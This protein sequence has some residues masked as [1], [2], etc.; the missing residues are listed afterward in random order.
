MRILKKGTVVALI[1]LFLIACLPVAALAAEDTH[2]VTYVIDGEV[3][4]TQEVADGADAVAPEIP[5][6][7]GYTQIAP[8]WDHDGKNIT[9]DISI[10][11]R[12][13]INEY[14][15]T[16]KVGD[17]TYKKL[18]YLHGEQVPMLPV[19]AKEGYTAAWDTVIDV[20][21]DDITVK[22]VYTEISESTATSAQQDVPPESDEWNK[23]EYDIWFAVILT[24]TALLFAVLIFLYLQKKRLDR[25]A[26]E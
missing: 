2:T 1:C 12:Y 11:A 3:V 13:T 15:V 19:P 14:V 7:V 26:K 21:T 24:A 25:K 10:T 16:Y 23:N 18:T 4:S 5:E 22:A 20:L 9:E 17:E 6:K 8:T